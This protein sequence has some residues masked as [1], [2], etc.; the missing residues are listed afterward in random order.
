MVSNIHHVD[1]VRRVA[2]ELSFQG[3]G[4]QSVLATSV[5][6]ALGHRTRHL[7]T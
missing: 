5:G 7:L 6:W 2:D 1:C 4:G 3:Q